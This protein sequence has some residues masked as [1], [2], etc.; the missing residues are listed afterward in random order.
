MNIGILGS[1]GVAQTLAA[2]FLKHGHDVTLGT[3][4]PDKL[5]EWRTSNA[6]GRVGSFADAAASA[7][8]IV[9]AV[10]GS[11]AAD[12]MRQAGSGNVAG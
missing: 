3:R 6:A 9:L 5:G 7:E 2:G 4:H 10:K 12:A 1:G 8:V 11:A